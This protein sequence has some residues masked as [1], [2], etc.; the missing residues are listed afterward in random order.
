MLTFTPTKARGKLGDLIKRAAQGED[1]GIVDSSTG[2]IVALRP[3]KV[4]SEDYAFTEYGIETP[5]MERIA[6]TLLSKHAQ[7][8]AKI[9]AGKLK[10]WGAG[11]TDQS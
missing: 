5:E 4:Y 3:V 9:K 11:T 10:A 1:I 2:R 6:E 7:S 8:L